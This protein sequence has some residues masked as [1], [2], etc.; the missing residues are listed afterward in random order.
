MESWGFSAACWE[1]GKLQGERQT[2]L[3]QLGPLT[4][5]HPSEPDRRQQVVRERERE[6]TVSTNKHGLARLAGHGKY[7]SV[8]C[9][10]CIRSIGSSPVSVARARV[11]SVFPLQQQCS[12]TAVSLRLCVLVMRCVI[13]ES[14]L[15]NCC[16]CW[17]GFTGH[18]SLPKSASSSFGQ[19]HVQSL[20]LSKGHEL[21]LKPPHRC[22][23][24]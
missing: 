12:R 4:G 17:E 20:S 19:S 16:R 14:S 5:Q 13:S 7:S 3:E 10:I 6:K 8:S 9:S 1:T 22:F 18:S 21:H 2:L 11:S 15:T 23:A 24:L